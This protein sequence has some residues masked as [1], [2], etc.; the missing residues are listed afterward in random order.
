ME[1]RSPVDR[2]ASKEE[3]AFPGVLRSGR[4]FPLRRGAI[5][6]QSETIGFGMFVSP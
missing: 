4:L 1:G 5:E 2:F 3:G 6:F